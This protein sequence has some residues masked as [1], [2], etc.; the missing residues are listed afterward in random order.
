[1]IQ[2]KDIQTTKGSGSDAPTCSGPPA[3]GWIT[4]ENPRWHEWH[5]WNAR[6]LIMTHSDGPMVVYVPEDG[7]PEY[8]HVDD[9]AHPDEWAAWSAIPS[10]QNAIAQ[11]PPRSGSNS[12]QDASGG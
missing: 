7:F 12:K 8:E 11:L 10:V 9:L 2:P 5:S 4:P 1:M 6:I 3:F